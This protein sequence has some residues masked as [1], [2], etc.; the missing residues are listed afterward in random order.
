MTNIK[1]LENIKQISEQ[2]TSILFCY[3]EWSKYAKDGL[4]IFEELCQA[5]KTFDNISF[6]LLDSA[7]APQGL[8]EWIKAENQPGMKLI[9]AITTGNG[10]IIWVRRGKVFDYVL[11]AVN[12]GLEQILVR[13][14]ENFLCH[15][16]ERCN[17]N[18][19]L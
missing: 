8:I 11:S 5:L 19:S 18:P 6:R 2:E 3:E 14:R 1:S 16:A 9:P 4:K 12:E 17:R 13:T 15:T 7:N 10:S